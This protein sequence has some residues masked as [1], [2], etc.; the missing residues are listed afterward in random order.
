MK[1]LLLIVMVGFSGCATIA[2]SGPDKIPV[3]SNPQGATVYLD[4][5]PVGNTPMVINVG[6]KDECVIDIKLD[7]YETYRV[8]RSKTVSGWV[9]GNLLWGP[10]AYIALGIDL[11]TSNQGHYSEDPVLAAMIQHRAPASTK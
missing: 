5:T 3:D 11:I 8:D 9:F 6:R 4:G 7:G 10:A 2:Q 1:T